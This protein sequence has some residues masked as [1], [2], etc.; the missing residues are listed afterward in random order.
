MIQEQIAELKIRTSLL[1]LEKL[2]GDSRVE[3]KERLEAL[4]KALCLEEEPGGESPRST[5][6]VT[7]HRRQE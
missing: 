6:Q 4:R 1:E 5:D 7:S 2:I 3:V